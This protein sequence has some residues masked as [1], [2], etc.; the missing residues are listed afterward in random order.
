VR[1]VEDLVRA[2]L[3][4][5]RA[6]ACRGLRHRACRLA[7]DAQGA[8]G[9]ARAAVDIGPCG[10]VDHDVRGPGGQAGEILGSLDVP[11][12]PDEGEH[13]VAGIGEGAHELAPQL[14]GRAGDRHA[15]RHGAY[16]T[17]VEAARRSPYC[18]R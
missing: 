16:S 15:P 11:P 7:V 12:G 5:Q 1:P 14:A 2:D 13:L 17:A 10:R 3:H 6:G 18:R 4:A 8:F 9:V